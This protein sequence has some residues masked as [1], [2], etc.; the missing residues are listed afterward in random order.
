MRITDKVCTDEVYEIAPIETS[1]CSANIYPAKNGL[2]RLE[3]FQARIEDYFANRKDV[4]E[5][6][7][8]CKVVNYGNNV[9]LVTKMKVTRGWIFFFCDPESNYGDLEGVKTLRHSCQDLS[10]CGG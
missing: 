6:V 7:I 9:R 5:R 8:K 4:I 2:D 1:I 3:C 10:K